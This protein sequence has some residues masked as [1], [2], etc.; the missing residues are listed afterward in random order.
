[1]TGEALFNNYPIVPHIW[2]EMKSNDGIRQ[3][4]Y[5]IYETG[6][7]LSLEQLEQKHKLAAELFMSQG[8][9]FT[10]YSENEGIERIFPFDIIPRIIT[11]SEWNHIEKGIQQRIKALNLF[12]KDIY[13]EQEIVKDGIIPADLIASCPHF[14][15]EVYGIKVPFDIYVHI[16]G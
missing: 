15:R 8:I 1:M 2:D 12:L 6:S 13:N 9:T 5:S 14:T 10:V 4:Y 16:A 11:G 7:Q 3:Q